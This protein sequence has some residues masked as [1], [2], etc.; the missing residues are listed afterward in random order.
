M[1]T[2]QK[3]RPNP[4]KSKAMYALSERSNAWNVT[5]QRNKKR[6]IRTFAFD[7][8]GGRKEAL[9]LARAWRDEVVRTHLPEPQAQRIRRLRKDNTSG[10]AGVRKTFKP[11]GQPWNWMAVTNA[12]EGGLQQQFFSIR[13]YGDELARAMAIAAREQ[14]LAKIKGYALP[15]A[16]AKVGPQPRKK[17]PLDLPGAATRALLRAQNVNRSNRTGVSGVQLRFNARKEPI[18]WIAM[19]RFREGGRTLSRRF[20]ISRHGMEYA[21]LLAVQERHVQLELIRVYRTQPMGERKPLIY[22]ERAKPV[23]GVTG[24]FCVN[25]KGRQTWVATSWQDGKRV[26]RH[27]SVQKYG[28]AQA[29]RLAIQARQRQQLWAR[30]LM[31]Q[32]FV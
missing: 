4:R 29:K 25:D 2:S 28:D 27:F 21:E 1:P 13:R 19:T 20:S 17:A 16:G 31:Q 7:I 12:S 11:D 8:Y 24:V 5:I 23:S 18:A 32:Q 26:S 3:G 14:Q 6:H 22:E 10:V 9:Q 30:S 15:H